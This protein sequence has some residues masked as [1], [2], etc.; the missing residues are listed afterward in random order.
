VS[1]EELKKAILEVVDTG[2][3]LKAIEETLRMPANSLSG[4]L[5]GSR[6]FPKKWI[7]KLEAYVKLHKIPAT[8]SKE[9]ISDLVNKGVAI[10]KVT[11]EGITE[12]IDPFTQEGAEIIQ[13]FQ[14]AEVAP[15]SP[16]QGLTKAQQLRWHRENSQTLQ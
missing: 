11:Q 5:S 7:P 12:R 16:P 9:I 14:Q 15:T 13:N 1:I 8:I 4:M 6:P 2:V 3:R 10:T